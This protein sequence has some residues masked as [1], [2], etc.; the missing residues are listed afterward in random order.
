MTI[1]GACV[2][3]R[4]PWWTWQQRDDIVEVI[5]EREIVGHRQL[6]LLKGGLWL[7]HRANGRVRS[8]RACCIGDGIFTRAE[9]MIMT[10]EK[11]VPL[12]LWKGD[13]D[14]CWDFVAQNRKTSKRTPRLHPPNIKRLEILYWS[15]NS[16]VSSL[17]VYSSR[18]INLIIAKRTDDKILWSPTRRSLPL[19]KLLQSS[20]EETLCESMLDSSKLSSA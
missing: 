3:C 11:K 9:R 4:E 19:Q 18:N 13:Q 12:S 15:S 5:R 7:W 1:F 8:H 2:R 20:N 6:D 10:D 16:Q 14:L 17:F